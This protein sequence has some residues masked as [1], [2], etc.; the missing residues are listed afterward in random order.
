MRLALLLSAVLCSRAFLLPDRLEA[1]EAPPAP[2]AA[3]PAT[4]AAVETPPGLTKTLVYAVL[5]GQIAAQRGEHLAA[6]EHLS[7]AAQL[8][9]DEDLAEKAARSA[10][11]SNQD[12]AVG[13]AVALWLEIAPDSLSAHQIAAFV[14]LQDEDLEGA[15]YHLRRLVNLTSDEGESGF[16]QLARLVHKLRPP[17]QRMELMEQLTAGEPDNADAWFARALVAAGSERQ[18]EAV[19]AAQRATELRPDWIEPRLFL[20]QLLK[21]ADRQEEARATLERFVAENPRDQGLQTL[22]AQFLVDDKELDRAREVFAGMLVESPREPDVL[23]ALGI[24][25]LQLEDLS[26]GRDYFTR[27]RETEERRDDAAYYLGRVEELDGKFEVA[28]AWY[29]KVRGEHAQDARIRLARLEAKGGDLDKA[30]ERLRL[31]RDQS[32]KDAVMLFMVEAE[33]LTE[34]DRKPEALKV[35]DAALDAHPDDPELLYARGLHGAAM[36]R[37]DVLETDLGRLLELDPDHADALNALGYSLADMTDRY[38]EALALIQRA[39]AL[40]PDEGAILDSLGWVHYRLGD[41]ELALDYL[42][43]ASA[44][45]PDDPEVAAHLGEVL[46]AL[47]RHDEA[48][49]VWDKGLAK[50]PEHAYLLKVVGRHRVS[51][52]GVKP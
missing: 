51:H 22:Y 1:G 20:V 32:R 37:L 26:S 8:A 46:F 38:Q 18:D 2:H 44:K 40:K 11:A 41:L 3:A 43:Q 31:M 7:R 36:Q 15:M 47:G 52:N 12:E 30:R 6:F 29:L 42:R 34:M 21:D 50:A 4:P 33:L 25:S 35:Y 14:R 16:V 13:R 23:F 24:L 10:L 17:G 28:S 19:T 27:L 9:R 45:I 48:W 39:L 5:A 49:Q